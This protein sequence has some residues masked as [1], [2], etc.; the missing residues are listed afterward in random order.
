MTDCRFIVELTTGMDS[1]LHSLLDRAAE[2]SKPK[3]WDQEV[4]RWDDILLC[5][6]LNSMRL[7][8]MDC[9]K[10]AKAPMRSAHDD[11]LLFFDSTNWDQQGRN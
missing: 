11:S 4:L 1:M 7:P 6:Q 2:V 8:T 9:W 10:S 3:G 5:E